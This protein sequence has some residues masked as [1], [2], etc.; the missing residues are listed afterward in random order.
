MSAL[1]TGDLRLRLVEVDGL[2]AK[3]QRSKDGTLGLQ[4]WSP[5]PASAPEQ[6]KEASAKE[7]ATASAPTDLDAPFDFTLPVQ[8]EALRV[9]DVHVRFRDEAVE[10]SFETDLALDVSVTDRNH[11]T[12]VDVG[13]ARRESRTRSRWKAT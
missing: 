5:P 8:L 13:C 4:G 3:A 1:L 12:R 2:V 9:H 7:A 11:A 6:E 10:P